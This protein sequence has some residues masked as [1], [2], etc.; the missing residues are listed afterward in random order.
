MLNEGLP[1]DLRDHKKDVQYEERFK[2]VLEGMLNHSTTST[3]P[4]NSMEIDFISTEKGHNHFEV[5][6][7]GWIKVSH[8]SGLPIY[9]HKTQRVCT[10]SKP[11]FLGPGSVRKHEIPI[12]AIPCLNYR[13]ALDKED[14]QRKASIGETAIAADETNSNNCDTELNENGVVEVE[15]G[16]DGST[17]AVTNGVDMPTVEATNGGDVSTA[18]PTNGH[19]A[20]EL[21]ASVDGD[22]VNSETPPAAE[23]EAQPNGDG[24]NDA[25]KLQ[26]PT[27]A[28]TTRPV[29]V[30]PGVLGTAKIETVTENT[31][32]QS[33]TPQ[34]INEYCKQLFI[35][36]KLRVMR[37]K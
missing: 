3:P 23:S 34:Q 20:V 31:K 9:L 13:R 6:P 28:T 12:T 36:K 22:T 37:F 18:E 7:E 2:T 19:S 5:L 11:Y 8:N 24:N 32:A 30:L 14:V 26:E 10:V 33:L 4:H 29:N 35:F 17:V 25:E 15:N 16:G 1:E 21:P 27:D